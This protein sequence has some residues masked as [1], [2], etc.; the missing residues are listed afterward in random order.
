MLIDYHLHTTFSADSVV[1]PR[2]AI[3]RAIEL[4]FD[5]ITVTDHMDLLPAGIDDDT[6]ILNAEKYFPALAKLQQEYRDQLT[7]NIGVEMGL[8]RGMLDDCTRFVQSWPFDFVIASVHRLSYHSLR[9]RAFLESFGSKEALY[10]TYYQ[11]IAEMLEG[12]DD[13]DVLGHLDFIRRIMPYQYSP[14]DLLIEQELIEKILQILINRGKGIEINTSGLR[15]YSHAT[16]PHLPIILRYHE[17][18]GEILTIGADSHRIEHVGYGLKEIT[19]LLPSLGI[20]KLATF[21]N[22]KLTLHELG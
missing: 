8:N 1:E 20:T 15:H 2:Q 22:R 9:D 12:F 18:G 19:D 5:E 13:F 14:D 6:H 11:T 4:G 16:L 17:L 3:E 10:R 21:K 7:I